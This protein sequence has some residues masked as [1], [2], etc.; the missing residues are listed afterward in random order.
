MGNHLTEKKLKEYVK[1][2]EIYV[3]QLFFNGTIIPVEKENSM[4]RRMIERLFQGLLGLS[5]LITVTLS[6]CMIPS[7]TACNSTAEI[8]VQ[9]EIQQEEETQHMVENVE[10]IPVQETPKPKDESLQQQLEEYLYN[11][12]LGAGNIA[13]CIQDM[14]NQEIYAYNTETDFFAASVYKFSLAVIYEDRIAEGVYTEDSYFYFDAS[15]LE[16]YGYLLS[17]YAPGSYVPLKD[18]IDI[19]ILYSDNSAGHIL[20]DSM[21]GWIAY[22]QA[23]KAYTDHECYEFDSY[24]NVTCCDVVSDVLRHL[25]QNKEKYADLIAL[26]SQAVP[27]QFL[28]ASLQISMPQKYGSYEYACNSAGFVEA[29]HPYTIVVLT[30]LGAYGSQVMADLNAIA[31]QH[32]NP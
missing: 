23:M 18:L 22:K 12:G 6:V 15:M 5:L 28:D 20:F 26:M 10:D 29:E 25:Y 1:T 30:G 31:Y 19:M 8:P 32:L 24:D 27:G 7:F 3:I 9:E 21:G 16:D 13:F 14:E 4:I 11:N 17:L 2:A